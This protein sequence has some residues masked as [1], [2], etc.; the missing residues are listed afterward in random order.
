MTAATQAAAAAAAAAAAGQPPQQAQ[1]MPTLNTYIYEHLIRLGHFD[2]AR[3]LL[4]ES[5]DVQTNGPTKPS[6]NQRNANGVSDH[7]D[8]DNKDNVPKRPDDLPESKAF[9]FMM[10][11]EKSF[12]ADW[13]F[14]FWDVWSAQRARPNA[15]GQSVQY[16]QH[17]VVCSLSNKSIAAVELMSTTGSKQT[18]TANPIADVVTDGWERNKS[19][20]W[21]A[22]G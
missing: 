16:L 21:T 12:L 11:C 15:S 10:N 17:N 3:A 22:Y 8:G 2:T 4:K 9:P 14:Q 5:N 7:L 6:P 19:A 13:W 20:F 18:A 1:D